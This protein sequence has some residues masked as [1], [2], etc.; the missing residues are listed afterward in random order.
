MCLCFT[1][2]PG[3]LGQVGEQSG[4]DP[5]A[6]AADTSIAGAT[7]PIQPGGGQDV[8]IASATLQQCLT[9]TAQSDRSVTFAA[10][11]TAIPASARV[12]IRIDV[13]EESPG[14]A[15]FRTISAPG[16]GIWRSSDLGVK[17]YR[18]LKQVT[19]LSAPASYRA[20]V[21]FRWLN[22]RGRIITVLERHTSPCLQP[23]PPLLPPSTTISSPYSAAAGAF[24]L[25]SQLDR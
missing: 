24:L 25:R 12:L 16:L 2:A 15:M 17:T 8:P 1:V 6:L 23:A 14:E 11:V 21:R 22:A 13:Q 10:E 19:N 9:A 4:T 3:A 7:Q 5:V 20:A 18:Y